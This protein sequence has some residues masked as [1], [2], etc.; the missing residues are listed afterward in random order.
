MA[1]ACRNTRARCTSRG[2]ASG[3][4][5]PAPATPFPGP[6]CASS[7]RPRDAKNPPASA[8]RFWLRGV[9]LMPGYFR[10]PAATAEVMRSGGW[11]AS[12]DLGELHADGALFVVGRIKEMIIRSGFNVYPGEVEQALN[13][14]PGILRSA[15]VGQK[16]ADGNEAVIAF[17]VPDRANPLDE[18][19]LQRHLRE[20]LAPYKR[21]ARIIPIDELPMSANGKLMRRQLLERLPAGE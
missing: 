7:I 9:G 3:A 20:Q 19:A 12:G 13:C 21:P 15:V 14:F 18:A 10:D 16:E 2:W 1:T 4:R 8:A 6:N 5:T 11:Y 17:I